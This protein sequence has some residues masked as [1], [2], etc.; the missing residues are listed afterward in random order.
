M[1]GNELCPFNNA[2][3]MCQFCTEPCNN[4]LNCWEC[5]SKGEQV[6]SVYLC[7]GFK[8][9]LN[10]YLEN[11]KAHQTEEEAEMCR[12]AIKLH[13][14]QIGDCSTCVNLDR[15]TEPGFVTDYGGCRMGKAFFAEKACGLVDHVCDGYTEERGLVEWAR[16][17]LAE[18]A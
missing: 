4:G 14:E 10:R 3:C 16:A 11:W 8:G 7:T 5:K 2:N 13:E 9:D 12:A 15:S 17:R 6:H 18:L 1:T